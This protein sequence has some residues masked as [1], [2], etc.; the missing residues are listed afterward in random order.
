M[1]VRDVPVL[2]YAF[3]GVGVI[4][5]IAFAALAAMTGELELLQAAAIAFGLGALIGLISP[6]TTATFDKQRG[7]YEVR[8]TGVARRRTDPGSLSGIAEV[9]V[10]ESLTDPAWRVV[11]VLHSGSHVPLESWW[12]NSRRRTRRIAGRLA[13]FLADA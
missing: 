8:R 2:Q 3:A 13:A 10:D 6:V 5:G 11:L 12:S 7:T 9:R 1:V 4:A